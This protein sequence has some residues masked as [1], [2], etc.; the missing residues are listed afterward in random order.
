MV[1]W[2]S[3]MSTFS[4]GFDVEKAWVKNRSLSAALFEAACKPIKCWGHRRT[5]CEECWPTPT[6]WQ[7]WKTRVWLYW[8]KRPRIHW[9]PCDHEDCW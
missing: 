2:V 7:S 4:W 6:R 1:V 3:A 9:G 5:V 8:D